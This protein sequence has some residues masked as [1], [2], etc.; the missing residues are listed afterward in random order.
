MGY[1]YGFE[2]IEIKNVNEKTADLAGWLGS[3]LNGSYEIIKLT[4]EVDG[5]QYE[6]DEED[7]SEDSELVE[8]CE[9]FKNAKQIKVTLRSENTFES[10]L[11]DSECGNLFVDE[12]YADDLKGNVIYHNITYSDTDQEIFMVLF[13]VDGYK[14]VDCDST[15]NVGIDEVKDVTVWYS[16]TP[17]IEAS[18]PDELTDNQ[19]F[20]DAMKEKYRN[21]LC[22]TVDEDWLAEYLEGYIEDCFFD[23]TNI[24]QPH[25]MRF[26]KENIDKVVSVL[27][28]IKTLVDSYEDVELKVEVYALPDGPDD[29]EF[30]VLEIKLE[31]SEFVIKSARI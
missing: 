7:I 22:L 21:L 26:K 17:I 2:K 27:N 28:D 30:A 8:C 14:Y 10:F 23:E 16:N 6:C 15:G 19:E 11:C 24:E 29:Y 12:K 4:V 9:N 20:F 3:Y 18:V 31:D 25:A 5:K 1:I 13:D